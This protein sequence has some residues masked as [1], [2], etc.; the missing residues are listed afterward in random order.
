MTNQTPPKAHLITAA[1]VESF[2]ITSAA[3]AGVVLADPTVRDFVM[4]HPWGA[5]AIAIATA[6]IRG[7]QAATVKA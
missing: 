4:A 5:G 6:I 7:I 1:G 2:L 3:I